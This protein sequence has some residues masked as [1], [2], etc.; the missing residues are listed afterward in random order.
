MTGPCRSG[1]ILGCTQ[2]LREPYKG[3]VFITVSPAPTTVPGMWS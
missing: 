2:L 3:S 1:D